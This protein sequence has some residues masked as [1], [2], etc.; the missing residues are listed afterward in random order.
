MNATE[1]T[2]FCPYSDKN[3]VLYLSVTAIIIPRKNETSET[4]V[5]VFRSNSHGAGNFIIFK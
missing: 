1:M 5:N 3:E 4:L 2:N